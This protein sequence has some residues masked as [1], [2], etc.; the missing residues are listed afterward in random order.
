MR[1]FS[2]KMWITLGALCCVGKS[3]EATEHATWCIDNLNVVDVT[4]GDVIRHQ[5]IAIEG[6]SIHSITPMTSSWQSS[7]H[8]GHNAYVIPGL[9]DMHVHAYEPGA[10]ALS[11]SHGVTHVRI[12]NG[13]KDH[14]QWR[15]EI[16]RGD[17]TGSTMTV[18]SPIL[19]AYTGPLH[20]TVL[21]PEEGRTAVRE[22]HALGYDLIKAYGNLSQVSLD[23]I[24][25]EADKLGLP[26]AKHGPHASDMSRWDTLLGYQTLEHVEDILQGPMQRKR[27][28]NELKR[29]VSELKKINV[30]ISSTL[31]IYWQLTQ[32]SA[33]KDAFLETINQDYIS[34]IIAL[35]ESHNQVK[36]WLDA[37][38][39]TAQHNI[40]TMAFL[41]HITR[42]LYDAGV[43]LVVGSDAGVLLSP[44]GLATHT[45]MRLMVEAGVPSLTVLQAATVNAAEALNENKRGRVLSGYIAD[46]VLYDFNPL[47][48]IENLS[49]PSGLI[50][51]GVYFE[52]EDLTQL[53][54]MAIENRSLWQEMG[55]LYE[56]L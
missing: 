54:E 8:D 18:S 45:E 32:L 27:D 4:T 7:C 42:A 38:Q 56:A 25:S 31:S 5:R 13:V 46:L 35:E 14:L 6:Q 47:Y 52:Q 24:K 40:E 15:D 20:R 34:S 26:V 1:V 17:R 55:T 41:K 22:A 37:D 21:T 44:L 49:Y 2:L 10:F 36:R 19:S 16:A 43:P 53:R 51:S 33:K 12:M 48:N 9:I 30:P 29:V 28:D 50:K 3:V 23:A 39:G 11:L